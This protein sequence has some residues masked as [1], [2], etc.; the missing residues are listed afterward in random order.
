MDSGEKGVQKNNFEE[1]AQES[2]AQQ[3]R[4]MIL[5]RI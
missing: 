3:D 2:D 5:K 1:L 4:P